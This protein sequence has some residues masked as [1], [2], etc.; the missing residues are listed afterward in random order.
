MRLNQKSLTSTDNLEWLVSAK[1]LIRIVR[2]HFRPPFLMFLLSDE[3]NRTQ[4]KCHFVEIETFHI[5]FAN[6]K[7]NDISVRIHYLIIG[8]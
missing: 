8:F 6:N 2:L 1:V 4:C 5:A 3:K 7:F